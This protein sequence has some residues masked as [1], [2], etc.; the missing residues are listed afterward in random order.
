VRTIE[1]LL[2]ANRAEIAA[3]IVRTARSMGIA[4]VAVHSD[5]D[6]D[7]P[8]VR[9]A[10]EAVRLPGASP[11][12]T[13]LDVERVV[14]AARRSGADAVHPGYGFLAER[15]G[16]ARACAEAG[17]CFVGPSP[18]VIEAM[19]SKVAARS[20][21]ADAGVPVLAGETVHAGQDL[22]K[23][24]DRVGFPLLVKAVF[25]GGGRGMR[26]VRAPDQL[27]EAVASAGREAAAAFGDG[28]VFL[29]RY[30]E[31]PRHVEVQVVGD[32][33]GHVV[34]LF[35]RDCSVQRRF[36]KVIEEAP[37]P[38]LDDAVRR[39][40]GEAAVTAARAIAYVGAGTVEFV[41]DREDRFFFLEVNTRLQVEH[42]V[43]ELVTGL[44]LVEV[45]LRVAMGEALPPVVTDAAVHGHA[46]EARLY[47]EDAAAGFVPT[48]GVIDRLAVAPGPGLRV[49]AGYEAGS[50]V[51]THYDAM[52]GKVVA[53]APTR[54]EAIHRLTRALRGAEL[55]GPPTN[56]DLLVA[57][58]EHAEFRAGRADTGF[59][60]RHPPDQLVAPVA[61]GTRRLHALA[62]AL[63]RQ[64]DRRGRAA[65][66][67]TV[68]SGWRNVRSGLAH[69]VLADRE[70]A[71]IVGY[72]LLPDGLVAEVGGEAVAGTRLEQAEPSLVVLVTDG[73][74]RRYRV[75]LVDERVHVD[76][77][78]GASSFRAVA[79]FPLPG[80]AEDHGS[81]HAPLPGTIRSVLVAPGDAV[82]AGDPLVVL[83]A[84]KMEHE[85]R[86]PH[87]GVVRAVMVA[88]A[89][90]VEE[91]A[92]LVVLEEV[93][94]G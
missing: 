4:T 90:Q 51:T 92:V 8:Y 80:V 46:V 2:V 33:H 86:A 89:D 64:A 28:A 61:G 36:Q 74:A 1:K 32:T 68:P 60:D 77:P 57:V 21:M 29:E 27:A 16:F 83:E 43:T 48:S 18:E 58:L 22:D 42:P 37:A 72:A 59:L 11:T 87:E 49:D 84:M 5:A 65:V 26:V 14:E 40:L 19:G 47:A 25:G 56:R 38:G 62:G 12:E 79:R 10:D 7:L 78:L 34:H 67:G 39:R 31:H 70:G 63:A 20:L 94:G 66:Q 45:Q 93:E 17:L 24:A 71:L 54:D 82:R 73:V 13:Y 44:D 91:G 81:L 6:A 75:Q 9:L 69:E 3:R 88:E 50:A 35:E 55:H 15:A 85:V 30:V 53:W 52:L 76:S 23:A 41:V